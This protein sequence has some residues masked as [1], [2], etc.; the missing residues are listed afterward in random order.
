MSPETTNLVKAFSS[1]SV[2][3]ANI[4]W[5]N[6]VAGTA[7][8]AFS[9]ALFHPLDLVKIRWQVYENAPGKILKSSIIISTTT[10]ISQAPTYR[11][12]YKNLLDTIS[13]VYKSESG[14]RGLYRG[15][16]INTMASGSAWGIFILKFEVYPSIPKYA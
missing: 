8:G 9:T 1:S 16:V 12:K 5:K 4:D 14:L 10:T 11:P 7:G 3:L 13:T 15:V 2:F 6:F